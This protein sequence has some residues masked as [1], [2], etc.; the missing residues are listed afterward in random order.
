[1]TGVYSDLHFVCELNENSYRCLPKYSGGN[2]TDMTF[3]V[4]NNNAKF[5]DTLEDAISNKKKYNALQAGIKEDL[6]LTGKT[7]RNGRWTREY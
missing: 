4:S 2:S 5:F 7:K 1:M 6:Y 3:F